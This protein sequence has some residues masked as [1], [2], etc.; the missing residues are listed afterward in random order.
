MKPWPTALNFQ[1]PP[2]RYTS[3]NTIAVSAEPSS[4][5]SKRAISALPLAFTQRTKAWR[6]MPKFWRRASAS[7]MVTQ[8]AMRSTLA[9]TS[10]RLMV[11]VSSS[12]SPAPVRLSPEWATAPS[13]DLRLL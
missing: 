7:W 10:A 8:M 12:P 2:L 1:S 4:D 6:T 11:T 13:T 3:P 9:G 5:R